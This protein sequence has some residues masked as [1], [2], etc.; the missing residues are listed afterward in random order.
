MSR[1]REVPKRR[2]IP[3]PNASGYVQTSLGGR[4][5][6]PPDG[7]P[8]LG[9]PVRQGHVLAQVTPSAECHTSLRLPGSLL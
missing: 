8:R 1:L 6:A 9:T 3:D 4:L 2:I 7:F 5:S